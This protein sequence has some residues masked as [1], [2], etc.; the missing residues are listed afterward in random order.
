MTFSEGD[1]QRLTVGF[2]CPTIKL[3]TKEGI[4]LR[5]YSKKG[6]RPKAIAYISYSSRTYYNLYYNKN[7]NINT[8]GG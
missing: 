6:T 1:L 8:Y 2:S 4:G 7:Y 3:T 5:F